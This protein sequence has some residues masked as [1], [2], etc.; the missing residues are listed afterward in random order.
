M[1]YDVDTLARAQASAVA[2]SGG[3]VGEPAIYAFGDHVAVKS[4]PVTIPTA[5][6]AR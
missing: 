1:R 4:A 5:V 6:S 3:F 2:C